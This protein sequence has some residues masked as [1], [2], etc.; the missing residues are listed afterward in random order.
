MANSDARP[1]GGPFD[2]SRSVLAFLP[3]RGNHSRAGPWSISIVKRQSA[4]ARERERETTTTTDQG[5]VQRA[6][7]GLRGLRRRPSRDARAKR[8][9]KSHQARA[10]RGS[11]E[12]QERVSRGP[13]GAFNTPS[14]AFRPCDSMAANAGGRGGPFS[15]E[16]TRWAGHLLAQILPRYEM[17][18]CCWLGRRA[19]RA[20]GGH[21][22]AWD[23]MG[24]DG[25]DTAWESGR[26]W[27]ISSP[28]WP[29]TA[30]R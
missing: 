23:G 30:P 19:R 5:G 18:P 27:S 8:W 15:R 7:V 6:C 22:M 29:V 26:P 16:P 11:I 28:Q 14:G 10:L 17:P 2:H 1:A 12:G 21:G 4:R 24:R 9:A 13:L 25:Q 3:P 20:A